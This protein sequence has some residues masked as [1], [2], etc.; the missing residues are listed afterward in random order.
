MLKFVLKFFLKVILQILNIISGIFSLREQGNY[1]TTILNR[2]SPMIPI[3]FLKEN[4]DYIIL[5]LLKF[6]SHL[7]CGFMTVLEMRSKLTFSLTAKM[8]I[9]KSVL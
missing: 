1:N 2:I 4:S 8:G 6:H 5:Q 3:G 9:E 7:R